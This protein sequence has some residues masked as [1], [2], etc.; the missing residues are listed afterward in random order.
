MGFKFPLQSVLK[1]RKRLE[2]MAQREFAEAQREVDEALK[3]LE[4]MYKR[5]D[6]VREEIAVAQA[7]GAPENLE[8]IRNM[9]QF[10]L[11]EKIRIERV[12]QDARIL[13]QKAEEKQE[14]LIA[15]AQERKILDK[16][17]ERRLVEHQEKLRQLEVKIAD[18]QTMMR[19]GWGKR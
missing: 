15:R 16:L 12:R 4:A 10:L 7:A 19:Q 5:L 18:D 6:E 11:G 14:A 2:E 17:R 8:Q 9:E 13:L 3:R 1:H